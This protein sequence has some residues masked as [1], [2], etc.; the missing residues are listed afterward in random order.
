[1]TVYKKFLFKQLILTALLAV[2]SWLIFSLVPENWQTVA[3]PYLLLFFMIS[4]GLLFWLYVR[5]Q[6]KKLS[7]FTNFFMIAMFSK[8]LVYL[9][10]IVVYVIF[11]RDETAPFVL[12]FFVY[13]I[14]FTMFEVSAIVRMQKENK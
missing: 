12:T 5:A 14:G 6:Q 7:A 8:L 11:N 13:Y 3:W 10:I 2:I 9:A 1:M 4:N